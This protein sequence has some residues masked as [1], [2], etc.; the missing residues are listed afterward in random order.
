[1]AGSSVLAR[2]TMSFSTESKDA[3]LARG[4]R[5]EIVRA[6]NNRSP[7]SLIAMTFTRNSVSP[8]NRPLD[9]IDSSIQ[10]LMLKSTV[11]RQKISVARGDHNLSSLKHALR[12]LELEDTKRTM[13]NK[14]LIRK[15]NEL[16]EAILVTAEDQH[17]ESLNHKA[18]SQI[19]ER[20]KKN[21]L[22]LILRSQELYS[23]LETTESILNTEKKKQLCTQ[24]SLLQAA[25]AYK[26]FSSTV[27]SETE[28][29]MVQVVE[30]QKTYEKS[31]MINAR[32]EEWKHFQKE[33]YEV[34]VIEDTSKKGIEC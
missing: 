8:T 27:M 10:L 18:Y 2:R 6:I 28:E 24:E 13:W 30:L 26:G 16:Q 23:N 1:M 31:Q 9:K 17:N 21:K 25:F 19:L 12:Q 29:G 34:A 5:R 3:P 14:E 33:M 15:I 20:M 7:E 11:D 32:N 22:H 4:K